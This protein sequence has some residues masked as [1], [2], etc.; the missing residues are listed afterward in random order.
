MLCNAGCNV[1]VLPCDT[2]AD[3]LLK[4]DGI[5]VSEGPGNP[6]DCTD[7]TN[8]IKKLIEKGIVLYGCGLGHQLVSLAMGAKTKKHPY[9]HRG[10]NQPV[11]DTKTDK[12]YITSQNHNY[13]VS[14]IEDVDVTYVNVNDKS[15]EGFD[16]LKNKAYGVQ[17]IPET[18]DGGLTVEKLFACV[19]EEVK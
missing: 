7:I 12:I 3:E 5:V 13:V 18:L 4:Y 9:G 10:A 8:E 17:F 15:I 2:C 14:D 1:T 16:S 6:E 19:W 11:K